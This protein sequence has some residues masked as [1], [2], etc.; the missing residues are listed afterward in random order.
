MRQMHHVVAVRQRRQ[1]A[2]EAN[3]NSSSRAQPTDCGGGILMRLNANRWLALALAVVVAGALLLATERIRGR[4]GSTSSNDFGPWSAGEVREFDAYP[5]LW[6]GEE[7][8]GLR[9][10]STIRD[11]A[12][13]DPTSPHRPGQDGFLFTYGDCDPGSQDG[14]AVP[15]AVRSTTTC[16][17]PGGLVLPTGDDRM[18]TV[19]GAAKRFDAYVWTGDVVVSLSGDPNLI[20]AAVQSLQVANPGGDETFVVGANGDLPAPRSRRC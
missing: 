11:I 3:G 14:C 4:D 6:L 18:E 13:D 16:T 20:E 9:L 12:E 19:R 1:F 10:S 7:F 17:L 8:Q 5:V 15:F 2:H